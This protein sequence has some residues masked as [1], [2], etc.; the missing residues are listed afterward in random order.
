MHNVTKAESF[1]FLQFS[2]SSN[3]CDHTEFSG[4]K[5]II[6]PAILLAGGCNNIGAINFMRLCLSLFDYAQFY[7]LFSRL[8]IIRQTTT[9]FE[10]LHHFLWSTLSDVEL[11]A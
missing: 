7:Y 6:P 2:H 4:N 9:D 1:I 5:R 3:L 8:A 10:T 11:F